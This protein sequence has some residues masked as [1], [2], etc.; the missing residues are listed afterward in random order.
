MNCA[1]LRLVWVTGL[2]IACSPLVTAQ[3]TSADFRLSALERDGALSWSNAFSIGVCSVQTAPAPGGPW[4]P[5][6]NFF[7]TNS[8]G[9]ARV[10]LVSSNLFF[11]LLAV[12]ISTNSPQHYTNLL[13]SYGRLETIAGKGQYST[14]KQNNWLPKYEGG[15]ATNANLSRPHIA[16]ADA[17]DNI[18]LVDEGSSSVLKITPAGTIHTYAGNQIRGFNGDGPAPAT[19]LQLNYPNGGW[20]LEDGTLYVMDTYNGKIRRIATNGIM[21][22][23]F[24][25]TAPITEGRGLWVKSDESVIYFA[26]GTKL[27]KWTPA[28]GVVTL[29]NTFR[30]LGNILGDEATGNLYITDRDAYRVY[31]M[32]SEGILTTIAGNGA[33]SG[34][35]DGFSALQTGLNRPRAIW[36]LPNGGYFVSEHDGSRIWYVDP[37]GIIH[38]W[39][40][41]AA[42]NNHTGDGDWFHTSGFKV[43]KVRSVT[44]DRH[45]N[46]LIVEN[47]YGYVRRINFRRMTP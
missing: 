15:P 42:G 1:R 28:G 3:G 34:G 17:A 45:G 4:S 2:G 29:P 9:Q 33:A 18:L 27:K 6:E 23:V 37:A 25:T 26:A 24:T 31:R 10:T 35:G 47:D 36:F 20:L 38:L 39:L 40:N 12:D 11:R 19:T 21:T 22:T 5:Q 8:V 41:G 13:Y 14:D 30:D 43:S 46:L 32:S 16:F 44:T 7:T